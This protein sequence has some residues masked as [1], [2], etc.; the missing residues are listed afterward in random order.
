MSVAHIV[1]RFGDTVL[2]VAFLGAGSYR[3]HGGLP[4]VEATRQ[5]VAVGGVTV[6]RNCAHTTVRGAITLEVTVVDPPRRWRARPPIVWAPILSIAASLIAQLAIWRLAVVTADPIT[7]V[8]V[9]VGAP[10][11]LPLITARFDSDS[12]VVTRAAKPPPRKVPI[13]TDDTPT[14][15]PSV[16]A[17][18]AVPVPGRVARELT[19]PASMVDHG[20]AIASEPRHLPA[21]PVTQR[22]LVTPTAPPRERR[23]FDPTTSPEFDSYH[24]GRYATLSTGEKTGDSYT[25][26]GALDHRSTIIIECDAA[27]CLIL[28]GDATSPVR[29]E[30]EKRLPEIVACYERDDEAPG[31]HVQLDFEIGST[32][33]TH[34]LKVRG[35]G[36]GDACVAEIVGAIMFKH[37][38]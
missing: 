12:A 37:D 2:D 20:P 16:E 7:A 34:D 17:K 31:K 29:R 24:V 8:A 26:N 25:T 4:T 10:G 38:E 3:A 22:S 13:T 27:S 9:D 30:L 1:V 5:G 35:V 18:P 33:R 23:R 28:G 21:E 6:E 15:T 32:G 11:Q 36:N 19:P 14:A